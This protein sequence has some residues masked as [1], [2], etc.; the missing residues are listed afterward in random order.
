MTYAKVGVSRFD[1]GCGLWRDGVGAK[2]EML[3]PWA[4]VCAFTEHVIPER[5]T[6]SVEARCEPVCHGPL[7]SCIGAIAGC[8]RQ[9]GWSSGCEAPCDAP[10]PE[11]VF[12]LHCGAPQVAM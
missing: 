9:I 11:A 5:G 7:C 12:A 1:P 3:E 6:S 8:E 4:K 2:L 10:N